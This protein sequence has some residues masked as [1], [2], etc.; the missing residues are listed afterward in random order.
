MKGLNGGDPF[1]GYPTLSCPVPARM[2]RTPPVCRASV[3]DVVV[4]VVVLVVVVVVVF[5]V[6]AV[7]GVVEVFPQEITS[8][9][10]RIHKTTPR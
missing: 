6:V 1:G 2:W 8:I 4:D 3:V 7:V 9:T 5:D 10:A